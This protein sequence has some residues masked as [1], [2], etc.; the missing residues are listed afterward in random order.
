MSLSLYMAVAGVTCY[1]LAF[2]VGAASAQQTTSTTEART[3]EVVAV[4]G[5]ALVVREASGTK[6]YIVPD[7]FRFTTG[8]K[9]CRFTSS[10]P[11]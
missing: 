2:S 3:F 1:S 11:A 10:G 7:T 6:E 9:L 5:N 8:G 4:N